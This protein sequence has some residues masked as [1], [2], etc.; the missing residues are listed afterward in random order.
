MWKPLHELL[1][2]PSSSDII[3][4]HTVWVI[5]TAVQNNPAAQNAVSNKYSSAFETC[6]QLISVTLS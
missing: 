2:S 6:R 3:E 5:G 4:M 1:I